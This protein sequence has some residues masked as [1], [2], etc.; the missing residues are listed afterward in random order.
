[1][2]L[3]F[4]CPGLE[5]GKDAV[6]DYTV[7]I[8]RR[9]ANAGWNVSIIALADQHVDVRSE[10]LRAG[11]QTIRLPKKSAWNLR[12]QQLT[13]YVKETKPD[14]VSLQWVAFGYQDK[15]LP[16]TLGRRLRNAIGDIPVQVMCH[17]IWVRADGSGSLKER[18][19]SHLQRIVHRRVFN[20]LRPTLVHTHAEPYRKALGSIGLFTSILPL[21][22]NIHGDESNDLQVAEEPPYDLTRELAFIVFGHTPAEWDALA[23]MKKLGSACKRMDKKA[24]LLFVGKGGPSGHALQNLIRRG[25]EVGVT[26]ESLGFLKAERVRYYMRY[27][28]AGLAT[29]PFALWQKSGAVAAM[30]ASGLPVI[31]SR[32]D[33]AWRDDWLPSWEPGF[34]L[35]EEHLV[36]NMPHARNGYTHI[37]WPEVAKRFLADLSKSR[38][39]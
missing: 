2:N 22:S 27:A 6:G 18:L 10:G 32:F 30:R 8:A 26:V 3:L 14:W 12:W 4:I 33:G 19:Y 7:E 35:C 1:M 16:L 9:V 11:C 36:K 34:M 28:H 39:L 20:A 25:V 15:G 21:A 23:V 31:F 38:E 17:E 5:P 13:D 29:V 24:L 37:F